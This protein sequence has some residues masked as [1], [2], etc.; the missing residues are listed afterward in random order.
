MKFLAFLAFAIALAGVLT[1]AEWTR[2]GPS[3]A[4]VRGHAQS[5]TW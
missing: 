1:L 3:D 4:E 2:N 5:V